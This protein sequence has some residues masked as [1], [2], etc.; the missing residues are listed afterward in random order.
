MR[1]IRPKS[2]L[3]FEHTNK[4]Y[5]YKPTCVLEMRIIRPKSILDFDR[6]TYHSTQSESKTWEVQNNISMVDSKSQ[7]EKKERKNREKYF[8]FVRALKIVKL[9]GDSD[10]I[11][12]LS[13]WNS[14]EKPKKIEGNIYLEELKLSRPQYCWDWQ[15]YW[16][17]SCRASV[18]NWVLELLLVG[19]TC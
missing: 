6:K 2:I 1:I 10:T 4:W 9:E 3:G 14:L 18:T 19:T 11:Q 7:S 16:D 12:S 5:M 13:S 8:D 15:E 17:M